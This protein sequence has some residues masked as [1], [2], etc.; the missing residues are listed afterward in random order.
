[1]SN[2]I[3]IKKVDDNG[4]TQSES[5]DKLADI[6]DEFNRVLQ[7]FKMADFAIDGIYGHSS[8]SYAAIPLQVMVPAL[9]DIGV[10]FTKIEARYVI[11]YMTD[12][13]ASMDAQLY[14]FTDS[15]AIAITEENF[16]DTAGVW[17]YGASAWYDISAHAGKAL[18]FQTKRVG[19]TGAK[20][21]NIEGV[22]LLLKFS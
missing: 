14:D 16:A 18:R 2:D 20:S 8:T 15:V 9:A 19:G 7:P 1:M 6:R 21:V 10:G 11:S 22:A 12:A 17:T 3:Y 5:L 4:S 13:P